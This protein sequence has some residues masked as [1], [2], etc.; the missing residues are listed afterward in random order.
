MARSGRRKPGHIEIIDGFNLHTDSDAWHATQKSPDSK[1]MLRL[2]MRALRNEFDDMQQLA[3]AVQSHSD[4]SDEA[5]L[6][7]PIEHIGRRHCN[8]GHPSREEGCRW[9][10]WR[11]PMCCSPS[12]SEWTR[13]LRGNSHCTPS[14]GFATDTAK[15]CEK[16]REAPKS[17]ASM[18]ELQTTAQPC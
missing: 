16:I 15:R 6:I 1:L 13:C 18:T 9:L 7:E 14:C 4:E 10:Q 5:S 2:A 8:Q 17:A 12:Y 11:L 3:N